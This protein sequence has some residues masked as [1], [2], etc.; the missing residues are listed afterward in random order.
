MIFL[1]HTVL[2]FEIGIHIDIDMRTDFRIAAGIDVQYG[3][4]ASP[5]PS[6]PHSPSPSP[7][8]PIWEQKIAIVIGID[9]DTF[10]FADTG[11]GGQKDESQRGTAAVF[12]LPARAA[13]IQNGGSCCCAIGMHG[14]IRI[15][16]FRALE[17][18]AGEV[19]KC[20]IG[21]WHLIHCKGNG[22][23]N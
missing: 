5:S 16:L 19:E 1:I 23:A 20:R 12:S 13:A 15:M 3:L 7:S 9:I 4:L 18:G 6:P 2:I 10:L 17:A 11:I 14:L 21:E 22:N 8:G